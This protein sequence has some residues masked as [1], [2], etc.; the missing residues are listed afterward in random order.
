MTT[1]TVVDCIH[2]YNEATRRNYRHYTVDEILKPIREG[3]VVMD[4]SRYEVLMRADRRIY[5]DVEKIPTDKPNKINELIT[6]FNA[7]FKSKNLI[8]EDMK[9]ALT[10]NSGSPTHEGLSYHLIFWEYSMNYRIQQNC[11]L[12]FINS[13]YGKEF[14]DNVDTSVYSSIRLFKLPYYV[15]MLKTGIDTNPDN[16][17]RVIEDGGD[18]EHVIIQY[19][20]NTKY[21]T[22]DFEVKPEWRKVAQ[23]L[24]PFW[25]AG[26]IAKVIQQSNEVIKTVLK[27]LDTS[28]KSSNDYTRCKSN[29][30]YIE[31]NSDKLS[32]VRKKVLNMLINTKL[33]ERNIHVY[34]AQIDA[35]Y[36]YVKE[37][38]AKT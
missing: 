31:K 25:Q 33:N 18:L 1:I 8:Q 2:S 14:V 29:L 7:F 11:I 9:Y 17:H 22:H 6:A 16:H 15:G 3:K 32:P 38:E 30:E 19:I 27:K 12:E 26:G 10:F 5:L 35:L 37:T 24:S 20:D 36:N 13:E 28:K 4:C 34:K 21:L 23:T